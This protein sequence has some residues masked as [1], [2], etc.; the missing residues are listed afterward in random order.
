MIR[1][2]HKSDFTIIEYFR[3]I[4]PDGIVVERA[5][6]ERVRLE[7]RTLSNKGR[8]LAER[9]G[10]VF[11]NCALSDDGKGLE[12]YIPLSQC[13]LGI[14][15]LIVIMTEYLDDPN[16]PNGIKENKITGKCGVLLWRG[17]SGVYSSIDSGIGEEGQVS[18][19]SGDKMSDLSVGYNQQIITGDGS[20][21]SFSFSIKT[22]AV[23]S[24]MVTSG[25]EVVYPDIS[26]SQSLE[27]GSN[28]L[29]VTVNISF[30][31]APSA[32]ST[33]KVYVVHAINS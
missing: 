33:Y 29:S 1:Q 18:G 7:F 10:T 28:T 20:T 5:V 13:Y 14:G 30:A 21:K 22:S 11:E 3:E 8:F 17:N 19:G 27:T 31:T 6:P 25:D 16:F 9:R 15:E 26:F 2:N 12:V 23:V 4:N 32:T 24:V